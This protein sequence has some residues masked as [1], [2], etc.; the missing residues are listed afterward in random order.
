M[1]Q[2]PPKT[3]LYF[4]KRTVL[5]VLWYQNIN[6][7]KHGKNVHVDISIGNNHSDWMP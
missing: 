6:I 4:C 3:V 5:K 1:T 7:E 2:C